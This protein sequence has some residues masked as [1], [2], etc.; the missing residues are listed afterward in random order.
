MISE[1]EVKHLEFIQNIISRMGSNSFQIKGL[2]IAIVVAI[3]TL[4]ATNNQIVN[5]LL[6]P[7]LPTAIF[8]FL[9]SFYLSK[10]RQYIE[11]YNVIIGKSKMTTIVSNLDLDTSKV[12]K[13][14][15]SILSSMFSISTWPIY[16]PMIGFFVL[17]YLKYKS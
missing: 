8:W 3:L 15:N 5:Y 16:L 17:S 2:T 14:S 6:V 11:L 7:I 9:D 10:E 4:F 12:K 13:F 1:N